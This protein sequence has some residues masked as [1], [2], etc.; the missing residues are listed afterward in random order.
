MIFC[1][2]ATVSTCTHA[3]YPK[4]ERS[5]VSSL[6]LAAAAASGVVNSTLPLAST[7]FTSS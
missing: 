4:A 3:S 2:C 6:S 1:T 5:A 7:V